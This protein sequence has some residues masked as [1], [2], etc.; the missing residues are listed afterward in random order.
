[1]RCWGRNYRIQGGLPRQMVSQGEPLLAAPAR[2]SLG[3]DRPITW[4]RSRLSHG[5]RVVDWTARAHHDGIELRTRARIEY[6]GFWQ[7]DLELGRGRV[8]GV[9]LDLPLLSRQARFLHFVNE[10]HYQEQNTL[11]LPR[12]EGTLWSDRFACMAWLGNDRVGLAWCADSDAPFRLQ[13]PRRA[14]SILGTGSTATLRIT[15][16]D[17]PITL[18]EPLRWRF[19]LIATPT[20]PMPPHW[21][22]WRLAPG[23]SANTRILW[24]NAWAAS[25]AD[26]VPKEPAA[27]AAQARQARTANQYLLPYLAL[28]A[29]SERTPIY[30]NGGSQWRRVPF[31]RLQDEG[32]PYWIMCP[33]TGWQRYLPD[34]I[35]HLVRDLGVNGIYFDFTF[36]YR[37]E[38][39]NHPCGSTTQAGQRRSEFRVFATRKL[40]QAIYERS[41]AARPDTRI[42]LH[43]SGA[44]MYPYIGFGDMMLN[45]EQLRQPLSRAGGRYMEVLSLAALRA[46]YRGQQAG[47]APFVIPELA[48]ANGLPDPRLTTD[49]A[50]TNELLALTLLHDLAIWPIYCRLESVEAVREVQRRFDIAT[51]RFVPYWEAGGPVRMSNPDLL[52]SGWARRGT[53]LLVL[54]NRGPRAAQSRLQLR[55]AVGHRPMRDARDALTGESLV[56]DESGFWVSVPARGFRLLQVSTPR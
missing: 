22:D 56:V 11:A 9:R 12:R 2:I 41:K 17:H 35:A 20:R 38:A 54:V 15:L 19:G 51:A 32:T 13:D 8:R 6:D 10:S 30:R 27:L 47:L 45:G 4:A 3:D 26:P 29:L 31:S 37:C 21:R 5:A 36:P 1:V 52:A 7:I 42:L 24:W 25:H 16:I 23:A 46:E 53:A 14:L 18:T 55:P 43:T 40:L 33:N 44:L 39:G 49:P 50:P 48:T 34:Q 28:L